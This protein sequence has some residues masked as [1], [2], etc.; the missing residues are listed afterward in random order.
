MASKV[1]S[2]T[3]CGIECRT[4]EVQADITAGLPN[5][6]IVGLGGTSVQE[7][8]QRV[9]SSIKNSG[10]AF[11]MQRKTINLAPAEIRKQGTLFDLPIAISLL[12]AS[13]QIPEEPFSKAIIVGELTL[14]GTVKPIN[15]ALAIAQHAAE[16][17]F[18]KIIL[19]EGNSH[20]ASFIEGIEIIPVKNLRQ[21]I[22]S[23][24]RDLD[25]FLSKKCP[26]PLPTSSNRLNNIIGL[27]KEKRALSI[28]AAG[29]HHILLK[30]P[31]GTGKT[32]LA[33]A[34]AQLFPPMS[35][36]Q[37]LETSKIYS[38]IGQLPKS[39]PIITTRPFREVHHTTTS[40]ALIGGGAN[41]KPGE[42]TLSHNGILFLDEIAEFPRKLLDCLR[43]P[44]E[45][46]VIRISRT[47]ASYKFPCDF[48][49]I[50]A[51]NPCPCGHKDDPKKTCTCTTTAI[52]N[53]NSKISGPLLDRFDIHLNVEKVSIS[54]AQKSTHNYQ[55]QIFSAHSIQ[56]KRYA[57]HSKLSRN[58]DLTHQN[59][60][61]FCTLNIAS[62][63]LL[64]RATEKLGLSNRGY[65]KTIK[66]ARSIADLEGQAQINQI[67]IAEAIAY[68][69]IS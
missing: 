11:P 6:F 22:E 59:I 13:G 52:K 44:L 17:S 24:G 61:A 49:L 3:F 19:P 53:Y 43:Q 1:Y 69:S 38:I 7:S 2:T 16:N 62:Q 14:D 58:S 9:R 15:G 30:G 51:M 47:A 37:S 60:A 33:R 68:R 66:L 31:P 46:K 26:L 42:I 35:K 18:E 8:K 23:Q 67:H 5:F 40:T 54:K 50:A 12:V 56:Q 32:I 29:G 48:T 64:N 27:E 4:V 45:D 21:I 20:E 39:T 28:A 57:N 41:P 63:N 10:A 55:E 34:F 25:R 36:A 65:I